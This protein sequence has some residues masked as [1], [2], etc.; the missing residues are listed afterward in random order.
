[1]AHVHDPVVYHPNGRQIVNLLKTTP[2]ALAAALGWTIGMAWHLVV[3]TCTGIGV[4]LGTTY[5]AL[6]HL[7]FAVYYGFLKGAQIKLVPKNEQPR[8]PSMPM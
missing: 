3:L 6:R 2:F 8:N 1:M 7:I 4:V 5:L